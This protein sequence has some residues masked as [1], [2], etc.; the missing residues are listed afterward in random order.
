MAESEGREPGVDWKFSR[1]GNVCEAL[2]ALP[3]RY[4]ES[5]SETVLKGG[6]VGASAHA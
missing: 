2:E 3:R 6:H 5:H 4:Q 1:A